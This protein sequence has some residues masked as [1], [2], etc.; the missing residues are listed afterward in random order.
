MPCTRLNMPRKKLIYTDLFPYHVTARSNNKEHFYIETKKLWQIFCSTFHEV[1]ELYSFKVHAFVLMS[2]HYHLVCSTHHQ[3]NLGVVMQ[4]F[5]SKVSQR[6]NKST[7]RIN[8]VFGGRYKGS[9]IKDPWYYKNVIKYV[10]RNPVKAGLTSSVEEYV[11]STV[12]SKD[13]ALSSVTTELDQFV[14]YSKFL[15]W[16][17]NSEFEIPDEAI[18]RG[19][20]KT[21]FKPNYRMLRANAPNVTHIDQ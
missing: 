12:K 18:S 19:L 13:I 14:P 6:I 1:D 3:Y 9:L 11:F 7:S 17:N 5:Q 10:Y 21:E 2:N 8:H 15:P 20:L 16:L 4:Y